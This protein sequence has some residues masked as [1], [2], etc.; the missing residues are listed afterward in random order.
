MWAT[1]VPWAHYIR[2]TRGNAHRGGE[3]GLIPPSALTSS[4]L[5]L[6]L[7][8]D[9]TRTRPGFHFVDPD[10]P[11]YTQRKAGV[12]VLPPHEGPEPG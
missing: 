5:V 10:S 3:H 2:S 11:Y 6:I 12:G 7:D 8:P 9:S 4:S 1:L